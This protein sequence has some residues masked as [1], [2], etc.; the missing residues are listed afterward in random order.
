MW[1]LVIGWLR[2]NPYFNYSNI[3]VK[4]GA[5]D[6]V[7][8]GLRKWH[9]QSF[10]SGF[11]IISKYGSYLK[12]ELISPIK[13]WNYCPL[14][15]DFQLFVVINLYCASALSYCMILCPKY[16]TRILRNLCLSKQ[17]QIHIKYI[18]IS[19]NDNITNGS[20]T[21]TDNFIFY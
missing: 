16:S 10:L 18:N 2:K 12:Y 19:S 11:N 17:Y 9:L 3:L 15:G 6:S 20:V 13:K 21:Y 14:S 4:C 1:F 7:G 8:I 5:Q